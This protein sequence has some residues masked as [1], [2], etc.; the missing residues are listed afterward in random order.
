MAR[1]SKSE[2]AE[3]RPAMEN[4]QGV[5]RVCRILKYLHR[6]TLAYVYWYPL[7]VYWHISAFNYLFLTPCCLCN[8]FCNSLRAW[9]S[10]RMVF[11]PWRGNG[12]PPCFRI[13]MTTHIPPLSLPPS[14]SLSARFT[15]HSFHPHYLNT[16]VYSHCETALLYKA[17]SP[18]LQ[19]FPILWSSSTTWCAMAFGKEDLAYLLSH[20]HISMHSFCPFQ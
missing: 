5:C 20:F 7:D 3:L 11:P 8:R 2:E 10:P 17:M 19:N 18:P 13:S 6:V 15:L 12:E 14:L 16:H 4:T 1:G 9:S